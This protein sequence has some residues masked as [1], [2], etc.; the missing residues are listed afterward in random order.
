MTM[1][2]NHLCFTF[3][4]ICIVFVM[5]AGFQDLPH[6]KKSKCFLSYQCPKNDEACKNSCIAHGFPKGGKCKP[7]SIS[8]CCNGD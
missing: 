5:V 2:F 1:R 8:C 7:N 4:I 3:A 6:S